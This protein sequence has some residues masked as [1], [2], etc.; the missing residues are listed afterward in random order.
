MGQSGAETTALPRL[1][2]VVR[3]LRAAVE[4][5]RLL[6]GPLGP[7]LVPFQYSTHTHT[8]TPS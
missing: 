4:V 1:E 3:W 2:A 7:C 8:H 6:L 5:R